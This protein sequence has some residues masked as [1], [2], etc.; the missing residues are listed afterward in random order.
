VSKC[1]LKLGRMRA[2]L[3]CGCFRD[4]RLQQAPSSECGTCAACYVCLQVAMSCLVNPPKP[5]EASYE[6][7]KQVSR[8]YSRLCSS[9]S[10]SDTP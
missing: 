4:G 1:H 3:W 5:G 8:L 9:T 6:Q 7:H 2:L 10:S